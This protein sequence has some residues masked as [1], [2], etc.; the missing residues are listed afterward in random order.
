MDRPPIPRVLPA[1][2]NPLWV[3]LLLFSQGGNLVTTL[4]G[5]TLGDYPE[6]KFLQ[7][8]A[9]F[10]EEGFLA[11]SR[12]HPGHCGHCCEDC[13]NR[14]VTCGPLAP[15]RTSFAAYCCNSKFNCGLLW[16]K[17]TVFKQVRYLLKLTRA[18]WSWLGACGFVG[19]VV[20]P[21]FC[22]HLPPFF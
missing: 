4:R 15:Q 10:F 20:P 5:A 3:F 12:Q 14:K 11:A 17:W 19:F 2:H 22:S 7:Q 18:Y 13:C 16:T 9:N 8:A 1:Y 21:F 6:R